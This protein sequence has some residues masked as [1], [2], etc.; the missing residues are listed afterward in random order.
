[1]S[2]EMEIDVYIDHK[3]PWSTKCEY[4][5]KLLDLQVQM[6]NFYNTDKTFNEQKYIDFIKTVDFHNEY[7]N[8]N[9]MDEILKYETIERNTRLSFP[10]STD[11]IRDATIKE[12]NKIY[13]THQIPEGTLSYDMIMGN[14]YIILC[15]IKN[16]NIDYITSITDTLSKKKP[17]DS[18]I[19]PNI[20]NKDTPTLDDINGLLKIWYKIYNRPNIKKV[21]IYIDG[22]KFFFEVRGTVLSGTNKGAAIVIDKNTYDILFSNDELLKFIKIVNSS[23]LSIPIENYVKIKELCKAKFSETN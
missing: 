14:S 1:M 11:I 15:Y 10:V 5:S 2:K 8:F 23:I 9:T 12:I 18:I 4:I 6:S 19:L 21:N 13:S 22:I 3:I 20:K 7:Q 16:D 17:E